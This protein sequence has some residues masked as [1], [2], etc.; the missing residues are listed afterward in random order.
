MKLDEM[1]IEQ[2]TTRL[3]ELDTEVRAMTKAE[4]VDKATD[5]KKSLLERKAELE[6]LEQ[7]KQT[8]LD[9][10]TGKV[11]AKIIEERKVEKPMEL[12][13]EGILASKEYRSAF[14]KTLQ[15]KDLNEA[16]KRAMTSA[17]ASARA[18]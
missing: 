3:A 9:I 6:A 8:A 18:S 17:A 11:E 7:R 10:T 5:E 2:V 15:G 13:K 14:F 12:T 16:E 4:D 1:N